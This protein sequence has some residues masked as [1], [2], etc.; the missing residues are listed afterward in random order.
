MRCH[1][2]QDFVNGQFYYRYV[3][4]LIVSQSGLFSPDLLVEEDEKTAS[5]RKKMNPAK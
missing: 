4:I 3:T 2:F 5:Y 1:I